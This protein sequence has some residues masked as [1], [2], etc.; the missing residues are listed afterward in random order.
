MLYNRMVPLGATMAVHWLLIHSSREHTFE[1]EIIQYK[2]ILDLA[3]R[4]F[5]S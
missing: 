2:H 5:I 3:Q 1:P 4:F